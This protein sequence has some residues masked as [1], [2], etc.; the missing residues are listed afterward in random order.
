MGGGA[1][2]R[3][4]LSCQ[5]GGGWGWAKTPLVFVYMW[6]MPC[7]VS[8][9]AQA[10]NHLGGGCSIRTCS[11]LRTMYIVWVWWIHISLLLLFDN[12]ETKGGD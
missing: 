8:A 4:C 9:G 10:I 12:N 6:R 5:G 7:K 3:G 1:E 11:S 2:G